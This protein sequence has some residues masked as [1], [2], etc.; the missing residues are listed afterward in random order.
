MEGKT[1]ISQCFPNIF[2][3]GTRLAH[4]NVVRPDE[5]YPKLKIRTSEQILGSC[6]YI[7]AAYV[8]M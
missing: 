5:R 6:E 2:A 3:R 8:T 7:P 4:V 1:L